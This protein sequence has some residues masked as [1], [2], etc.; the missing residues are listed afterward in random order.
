MLEFDFKNFNEK[1]LKKV[2]NAFKKQQLPIKEVVANNR[3][4]RESGYQVKAATLHFESGQKLLLKAKANGSIFQVKLNNKALPIKNVDNLKKA[5]GEVIK[6]VKI[7]EPKFLKQQAKR[8]ERAKT[9]LP[10]KPKPATTSAKKQLAA[11]AEIMDRVT[12]ENEALEADLK[13]QT[14]K[15]DTQIAAL[16]D[17]RAR[18]EEENRKT[19][20]LQAELDELK[21]AA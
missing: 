17:F 2:L 6:F 10:K 16:A 11:V 5:V 1:G 19:E 21:E 20:T 8:L 15:V 9:P 4:K 13:E 12:V 3:P 14:E 7:N 18:L